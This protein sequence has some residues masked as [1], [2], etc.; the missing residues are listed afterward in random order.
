MQCLDQLLLQGESLTC[1][2]GGS[3]MLRRTIEQTGG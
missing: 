1:H 2:N 3:D